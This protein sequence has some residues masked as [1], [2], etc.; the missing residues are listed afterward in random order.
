MLFYER[1][2]FYFASQ[3]SYEINILFGRIDGNIE[4]VQKHVPMLMCEK[5]CLQS[6]L[7]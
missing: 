4:Y 7:T 1:S 2:F 6:A 5:N 3:S